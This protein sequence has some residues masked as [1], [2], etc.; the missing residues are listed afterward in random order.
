MGAGPE[1]CC[2]LSCAGQRGSLRLRVTPDWWTSGWRAEEVGSHAACRAAITAYPGMGPG[3]TV[4][5]RGA[6]RWLVGGFQESAQ[7][8]RAAPT[9]EQASMERERACA[10][11]ERR[12][13]SPASSIRSEE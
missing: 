2:R 5:L 12:V 8:T 3:C 1:G 9:A 11:V 10:E 13:G 6:K 7:R 4:D